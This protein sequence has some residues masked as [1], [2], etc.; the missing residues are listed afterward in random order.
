MWRKSTMTKTYR[1]AIEMLFVKYKNT[2]TFETLILWFARYS[3]LP[4]LS[5]H[6]LAPGITA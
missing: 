4:N 6:T 5:L 3:R 1:N 2:L